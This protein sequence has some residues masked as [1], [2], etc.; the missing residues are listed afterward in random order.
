MAGRMGGS[1]SVTTGGITGTEIGV[2]AGGTVMVGVGV[3]RGSTGGSILARSAG[4]GGIRID[5]SDLN[6][7]GTERSGIMVLIAGAIR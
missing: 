6:E 5:A 2:L 3:T 4:G 1:A 7:S